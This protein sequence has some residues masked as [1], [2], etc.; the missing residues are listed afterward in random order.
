M[1]HIKKLYW[2]LFFSSLFLQAEEQVDI[3]QALSG[4]V[5]Q[6]F[7]AQEKQNQVIALAARNKMLTQKM[8]KDAV[9]VYY[10]VERKKSYKDMLLSAKTFNRVLNGLKNG[11]PSLHITQAADEKVLKYVEEVY[12]VWRPFD[13]QVKKLQVD[14]KIDKNAYHY[15]L[16]NNEK[17]LR[18]SHKLTQTLKSESK[19][20]TRFNEVVEHSLKIADRQRMLSQKMFK[21]KLLLFYHEDEERNRA[22]LRGSIILF[23]NGLKGLIEGEN[24]RGLVKI[25][26]KEIQVPLRKTWRIWKRI[27]GIYKKPTISKKELQILEKYEPKLLEYSEEIVQDIEKSLDI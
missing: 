26:N 20:S 4:I 11:D 24:R 6:A 5:N 18:L 13:A 19:L 12:T 7:I 14:G 17:L 8:A 3:R 2:L 22:R 27:E 23:G 16:L 1:K 10:D 9:K 21:E 25:A 15:I